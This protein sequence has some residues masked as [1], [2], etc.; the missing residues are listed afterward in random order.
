MSL[1]VL[2]QLGLVGK[3][4]IVE[5]RKEHGGGREAGDRGLV[6]GDVTEVTGDAATG[7]LVLPVSTAATGDCSLCSTCRM[8]PL[9]SGAGWEPGQWPDLAPPPVATGGW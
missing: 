1:L 6:H 4:G 7:L 3:Q 8:C 2:K 5:A 9:C